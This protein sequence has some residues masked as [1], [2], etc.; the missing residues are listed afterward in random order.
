V[1]Q[2]GEPDERVRGAEHEG[3]PG[4]QPQLVSTPPEN[5]T[6][7]RLLRKACLAADLEVLGCLGGLFW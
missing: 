5:M 1:G 7:Y 2:H 3:D 4:Q 6:Q